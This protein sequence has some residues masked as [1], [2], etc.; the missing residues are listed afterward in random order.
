M[1]LSPGG[2]RQT[3]GAGPLRFVATL[4]FVLAVPVLLLTTNIRIA[5]NLPQLYD[6][7][8][9]Q[10]DAADRSG[11]PQEELLRANREIVRYFNDDRETLRIVV[12]DRTGARVSLFTPRETAHMADVKSLLWKL[13]RVQEAALA[14]V[15]VFM[16]AVYVWAR[17][18]SLRDL[19]R[20]AL[21]AAVL[22]VGI[23]VGVGVAAAAGFDRLWEQLHVLVFPNDFWL[24]DPREHHLIQMFPEEFWLEMVL[25]LGLVTLAEATLLALLAGGYLWWSRPEGAPARQRYVFNLATRA[26]PLPRPWRARPGAPRG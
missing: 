13:F 14:Y 6:Y 2:A 22:T 4:L 5:F 24:L 11:I 12:T 19:A 18:G 25:L 7:S 10:Y 9:R 23:V 20:A 16:V 15:L 26:R 1:P 17:E 8:V 3:T 21:Q